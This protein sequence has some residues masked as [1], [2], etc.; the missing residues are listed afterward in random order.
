MLENLIEVSILVEMSI[1]YSR[2]IIKLFWN[3]ERTLLHL[4]QQVLLLTIC[5][6]L[7]SFA[8]GTLYQLVYPEEANIYLRV[9]ISDYTV[10]SILSTMYFVSFL[11]SRHHREEELR[12]LAEKRIK[13]EQLVSAQAKI[14][15]LSLQTNNHFMFNCFSTL[16]GMINSQPEKAQNFLQGLS[17]MYRYLVRNGDRHVVSLKDEILFTEN[18]VCLVNYRYEGINIVMDVVLKKTSAFISPLSIQQLVENAVKHN[19]H[20][21]QNPLCIE[22]SR[23]GDFV[24]VRNNVLPRKDQTSNKLGFGLKNLDE[25]MIMVAGRGISVENDGK[26]FTVRIPLIFDEDIRDESLDY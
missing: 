19:R 4:S 24:L 26:Y 23:D 10:V 22:I 6:V 7:T 3:R 8:L 18:Y 20:G 13:E 9:F 16:G 2:V 21:K 11:I 12:I 25:R 5:N 1:F 17:E 15:K 14:D